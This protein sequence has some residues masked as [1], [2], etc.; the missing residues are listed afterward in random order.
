MA[1]LTART[2][3][4]FAM[5][6]LGS[7]RLI[8]RGD[9]K[10]TYIEALIPK[11]TKEGWTWSAHTHPGI[12]PA[13]LIPSGKGGDRG[14]LELINQEQSLILNSTGKRSIFGVEAGMQRNLS[15]N[16]IRARNNKP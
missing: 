2:G 11:L 4:E 8:V 15:I 1:A 3:D 5:F 13:S 14:L 9:Q 6:T 16:S 12:T 10:Y 7:R